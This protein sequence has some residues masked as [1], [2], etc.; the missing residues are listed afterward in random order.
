MIYPDLTLVLS[1]LVSGEHSQEAGQLLRSPGSIP[2]CLSIIHRLQVEN[3][4]LRYLHGSDVRM[5]AVAK[6]GML[7]WRQYVE[8]GV[9]ELRPFPLAEGF[10]QAAA[11]NAEWATQPPRWQLLIHVALAATERASFMSLDPT[12]RKRASKAGLALVPAK[13]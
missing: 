3:A 2:L 5:N 8:E 6:D 11:W 13:L 1:L 7:L 12:L 4:L 10:A 9:F